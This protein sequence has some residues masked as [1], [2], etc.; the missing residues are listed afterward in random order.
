MTPSG[1]KPATFRVVDA[2]LTF[3]VL[4]IIFREH[5]GL[6]FPHDRSQSCSFRYMCRA[7]KHYH[8]SQDEIVIL[9]PNTQLGG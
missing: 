3:Y 8:F 6:G 4:I 1:F 9:M 7:L 5:F 2:V